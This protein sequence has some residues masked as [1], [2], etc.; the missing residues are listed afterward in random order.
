MI[1]RTYIHTYIYT[2]DRFF[3]PDLCLSMCK[4]FSVN[5]AISYAVIQN[6]VITA[7]LQIRFPL[8]DFYLYEFPRLC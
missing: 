2:M 5:G 7:V 6:I 3:S 4:E 1:I 8:P